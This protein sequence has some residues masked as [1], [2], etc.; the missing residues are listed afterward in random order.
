MASP[1]LFFL[2]VVTLLATPGPTNT[3]LASGAATAGFRA[4]LPLVTAELAGYLV[5]VDLIG[6]LLR[7]SLAAHPALA[8]VLKLAVAVYLA[9]AALK[10]WRSVSS[11]GAA[12]AA[13]TWRGV[14]VAT[15]LNPKGLIVALAVIPFGEPAVLAYVLVFAACVL[16]IGTAW[17]AVGHL[18]GVA[19]GKRRR[20]VP[21]IAALALVGFA[22]VIAASALG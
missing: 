2:A 5:A 14:F 8:M 11:V 9:G 4:A 21:R 6:F 13:V 1:W 20:L 12:R 16:L 17:V 3:L 7:P 22:G 15:L 10:L 18:L 19:V